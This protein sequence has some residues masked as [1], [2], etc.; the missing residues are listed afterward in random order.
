MASEVTTIRWSDASIGE[1]L[2]A[3]A[4]KKSPHLV[5]V[6]WTL[7]ISPEG[8]MQVVFAA[9]ATN[10]V[11]RLEP[12]L[13]AKVVMMAIEQS[14]ALHKQGADAARLKG[15]EMLQAIKEASGL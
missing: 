3:E 12:S 11:E 7:Q 6:P 10:S 4:A 13:A 14:E 8:W 1:I 2:A 15:E 5:G 9:G